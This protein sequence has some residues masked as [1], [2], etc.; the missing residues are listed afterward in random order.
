MPVVKGYKRNKELERARR[1]ATSAFQKAKA[2][3]KRRDEIQRKEAAER[4]EKAKLDRL[5]T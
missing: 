1:R 2:A 3:Q 4:R 5:Y